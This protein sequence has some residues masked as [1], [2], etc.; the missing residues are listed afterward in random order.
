MV[1]S[2]LRTGTKELKEKKTL[3]FPQRLSRQ[4]QR[5]DTNYLG[6]F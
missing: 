3:G 6:I 2:N 4:V 5:L 1:G